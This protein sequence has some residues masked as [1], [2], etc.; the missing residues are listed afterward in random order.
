MRYL[1]FF[2]FLFFIKEI[3]WKDLYIISSIVFYSLFYKNIPKNQKKIAG[4]I[5]ELGIVPTKLA[6]WMGYFLRIQFENYYYFHL[7]LDSLP[8][9]QNQCNYSKPIYFQEQIEK[10][11]DIIDFIEDEPIASASIAQIYRG[12][13]KDGRDIVVKIKHDDLN[14]GIEK[15]ENILRKIDKYNK[16]SIDMNNFFENVKDQMDFKKESENI[17]LYNKYYRKNKFIKIPEFFGGDEDLIIM[18][19]IFSENFQKVKHTLHKRD[20]EHYTLLSKIMY[21]DNIFIKDIIHMDLHNGNW[22]IQQETKSIVLYD[23]GWVLKDQSDFKRFFILTHLGRAVSMKF[24]MNKYQLEDIDDKLQKFT[25]TICGG[26][27]I[28]TLEGIKLVLKMFP[29]DF[30]MDNFMFCVLSLCVFISSLSTKYEDLET[31]LKKEIDFMEEEHVFLPLC[32]LMK[33]IKNPETKVQL[34]QWYSQVENSPNK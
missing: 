24:F 13:S 34:Q 2:F 12:K 14:K 3:N 8:Y 22:G 17:K 21:Q 11:K 23:F 28:D 10:Y 30:K 19:Y 20:I 18:S 7:F 25:L 31:Y 29:N 32:G 1:R 5:N 6:Q 27:C 4:K 15:W 16:F 33:N 9:L 26:N